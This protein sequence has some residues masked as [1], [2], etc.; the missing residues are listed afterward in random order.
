MAIVG[1]GMML[2]A[3]AFK[4]WWQR[5]GTQ[6]D[7]RANV[8]VG[9][10]IYTKYGT[11]FGTRLLMIDKN[12]P[13]GRAPVIGQVESA[14]DLIDRLREV[15][16]DRGT[17]QQVAG[18]PAGTPLAP[19][20]EGAGGAEHELPGA[21][22]LVG[23]GERGEHPAP[24]EPEPAGAAQPGVGAGVPAGNQPEAGG[25]REPVVPVKPEPVIPGTA[26]EPRPAAPAGGEPG[27][28]SAGGVGNGLRPDG[29]GERVNPGVTE[30]PQAVVKTKA[31][32]DIA[33]KKGIL[34]ASYDTLKSAE[35][36][37]VEGEKVRS[38]E[39]VDQIVTW[40]GKDFDGVIAF[41][42]A[43]NM[44]NSYRKP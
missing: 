44:G 29:S 23:A 7:A 20:S 15:R 37:K 4:D 32:E 24:V 28:R 38:Q 31:G 10:K 16:D 33:A 9:G 43:H 22:G 14:P 21:T 25:I 8:G 18:Q 12:A 40:L 17:I 34:F 27:G 19:A 26:S 1:R 42:E 5:I 6:Y 3:P 13:S 39:R 41:D 35:K 2:D 36:T 11:S 30:A